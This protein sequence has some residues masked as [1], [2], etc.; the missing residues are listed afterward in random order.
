MTNGAGSDSEGK[1]RLYRAKGDNDG[2][3]DTEEQGPG[4]TSTRHMTGMAM[5]HP[6]ANRETWLRFHTTTGEYVTLV[7][8]GGMHLADV[9]AVD[10][11]SPD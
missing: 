1:D 10:N 2:I 9:H 4:G 3:P 6:I 5:A 8:P 11:P 7:I